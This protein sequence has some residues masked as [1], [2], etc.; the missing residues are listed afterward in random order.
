MT[1]TSNGLDLNALGIK[2]YDSSNTVTQKTQLDQSDFLKLLTTQ[3]KNQDPLKP[4]ENEAFVAQ[5]A[6]FSSL[7]GITEMN[8][9]LGSILD[10][11]NNNQL[12]T[13]TGLVGKYVLTS[14]TKAVP[15]G[16]GAVY[17]AIA[18]PEGATDTTLAIKDS[19]GAT[20]RT[21]K[22]GAVEDGVHEF[23]WDGKNDAGAAV[24][25]GPVSIEAT[26][27]VGGKREAL[28]TSVYALVQSVSTATPNS[29]MTLDL[30]GIGSVTFDKVQKISS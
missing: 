21:I 8:T 29:P 23:A 10:S 14:G 7:S 3:L 16:T 2:S 17:G 12:S 20:I 13:A 25:P 1:S 30:L 4:V 11:L 6:Q 22:L 5:M 24:E 9:K 27:N 15:D 19:T 28:A 18:I 26:A